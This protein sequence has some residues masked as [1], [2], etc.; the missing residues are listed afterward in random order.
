[1]KDIRTV[2]LALSC[3]SLAGALIAVAPATFVTQT[4]TN[5]T[6]TH[7]FAPRNLS[8]ATI[9]IMLTLPPSLIIGLPAFFLLRSLGLLNWVS[10]STLGSATG[11]A[12][13]VLLKDA[14]PSIGEIFFFSCI[15][16][17]SST[18]AFSILS[19]SLD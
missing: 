7:F 17:A 4:T 10:V 16:L 5:G 13:G 14:I 6:V 12:I 9:A 2:I 19:S 11:I 8:Y 1:M 18:T 15:G 3:G